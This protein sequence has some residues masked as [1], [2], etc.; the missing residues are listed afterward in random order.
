MR[1]AV[2]IP[3]LGRYRGDWKPVG[4]CFEFEVLDL[5]MWVGRL[6]VWCRSDLGKFEPCSDLGQM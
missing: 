6:S 2:A 1:H 3:H 4:F 5:A